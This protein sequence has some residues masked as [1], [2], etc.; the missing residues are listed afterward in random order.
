[1]DPWN[2]C[3]PLGGTGG[4]WLYHCPGGALGRQGTSTRRIETWDIAASHP[5]RRHMA[6][7][8]TGGTGGTAHAQQGRLDSVFLDVPTLLFVSW[9]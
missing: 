4:C 2:P 3:L 9:I 1:M 8:G 6:R 7:Q 5:P